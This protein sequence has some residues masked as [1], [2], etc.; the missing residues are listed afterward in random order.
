MLYAWQREPGD[1]NKSGVEPARSALLS[2]T[3]FATLQVRDTHDTLSANTAGV[4]IRTGAQLLNLSTRVVAQTGDNVP[5]GGLIIAGDQDKKVIVR[6]I[7][8]SL[9]VQGALQDPVIELHDSGGALIASN[10]NWKDSQQGEVE[11]SGVAPSDDRESAIV[12]TLSP[13]NYTVV[14]RGKDNSSGVALVEVYDLSFAADARLANLSTRG[15]VGLADDVMIGGF[16]AGP[17]DAT[18]TRV[19]LRAI[20]PI[21][22]GAGVPQAMDD[23][24]LELHNRDGTLI[25]SNDNWKDNPQAAEIQSTGLQPTIA[26]PP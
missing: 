25:D 1:E 20:G 4:E 5:I 14:L 17:N 2:D 21:L 24:T 11:A 8:P 26:S 6:G 19:V 12:R 7:G 9:Q 22:S 13:G 15:F 18:F 23:P 3:F 16:V 10:D